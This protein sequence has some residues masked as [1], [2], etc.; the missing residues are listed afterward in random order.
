[1]IDKSALRTLLRVARDRFGRDGAMRVPDAFRKRLRRGVTVASYTPIGS[2]ADP[3]SFHEAAIE[4]G[5]RIALPH[6]TSR[7]APMRFLQWDGVA[8]L[9]EGPFQLRQPHANAAALCPDI[10]LAPLLG[11]DHAGNRIGQGAG[12]YDRA[13]TAYPYAWRVGIAWSVQQVDKLITDP[14]DVALHAIATETD[15]IVP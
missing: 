15:W 5:C 14:W 13:F 9:V 8:P 11:F 1:M 2:E 10:I 4:A 6:V 3:A 12:H 7:A